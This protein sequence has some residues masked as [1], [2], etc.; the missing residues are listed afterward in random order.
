MKYFIFSLTFLTIFFQ[1]LLLTA[2]EPSEVAVL[3]VKSDPDSMKIAQHY[4]NVRQIPEKNLLLLEK[5][6]PQNLPREVWDTELRPLIRKWLAENP[7]IKCMVCAW[8]LPLRIES[9]SMDSPRRNERREFY[10][11]QQ[12]KFAEEIKQILKTAYCEIAPTDESRAAAE[13]LPDIGKMSPKDWLPTFQKTV[14]DANARIQ[15]LPQDQK[16]A[17]VQKLDKLLQPCLGFLALR[18]AMLIQARQNKIKVPAQTMLKLIKVVE[19][20]EKQKLAIQFKEDSVKR[21]QA[22]LA[23][24]KLLNGPF[25]AMLYARELQSRLDK[26]EGRSSFDSELSLIYEPEK[27]PTI[28]WLPNMFAAEHRMPPLI[29]I[30]VKPQAPQ[31]DAESF[32]ENPD[33]P[34][35]E[36]PTEALPAPP[37]GQN[38]SLPAPPAFEVGE[39]DSAEKEEEK[40][41]EEMEEISM[42]VFPTPAEPVKQQENQFRIPEPV[43][44]ILFVARLEGPSV[45]TVLKMI[46]DSAAVEK[47]GLEGAVYLD[48]RKPRPVQPPAPGSYDKMEQS[49][50]DLG[51]RLKRFTN[52]D[53]HLDTEGPL[54]KKENCT[55]PC[56]LY[57]GWYSHRNFQD[58]F[59]FVPG[60][61]AYHVA[62]SE[63]EDLKTAPF[64]CP[65]LLEHGAA[66]T[67]GPTFEPY[68]GAFPEPDPF[69]SLVLTGKFSMI[70]C[71]YYT[72]PFNSWAMT[73]VGDPLY[74]PFKQNPKLKMNEIPQYLQRFFGLLP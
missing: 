33:A 25:A 28:G 59:T 64:W 1:T 30:S 70:E 54:F 35:S 57:C 34:A 74:V 49:L 72:K 20:L 61:A 13:N 55:A 5:T 23:I 51:I 56:A 14:Q 42:E 31:T 26:N 27:Y 62:S 36:E 29:R 6:Y 71:W 11:T 68:L 18:N 7:E 24:I 38:V 9:Y 22:D 73:Y 12:Q 69:Y 41:E 37:I 60:A 3:A 10:V 52:L 21:D 44:R 53:V 63:A 32:L 50:N 43:R 8:S 39:T 48:A 2:L 19:E 65:N 17:E 45:Q 67:L 58:I 40:E 66:C 47:K 15:A 46:D 4:L 16:K